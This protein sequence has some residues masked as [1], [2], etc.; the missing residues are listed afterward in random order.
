MSRP[1][2]LLELAGVRLSPPPVEGSALVVIDAQGWYSTGPLALP[3]LKPALLALA[4]ALERA[5]AAKVPVIHVLHQGKPGTLFDPKSPL[6]DP[7]SEAAPIAGEPLVWKQMPSA[8]TGTRLG[9]LLADLKVTT[10]VFAGFMTHMCVSSAARAAVE[11]GFQPRVVCD[12]C[13]ARPLPDGQGGVI[14]AELVHRAHLASLADRFAG[15]VQA[16]DLWPQ[17]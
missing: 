6:T 17:G 10:P 12:A 2:T 9:S 11:L 16:A 15:L 5:R 4:L 13:A 14:D 3:G 8:F 1:Q 7:L